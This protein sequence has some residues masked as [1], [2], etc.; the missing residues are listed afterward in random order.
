ML[1][2]Q[3]ATAYELLSRLEVLQDGDVTAA[4]ELLENMT[5]GT[6]VNASI[7]ARRI[8]LLLYQRKFDSARDLARGGVSRFTT[9]PAVVTMAMS[10]AGV[11]WSAGRLDA[12]R[13]L[14]RAAIRLIT[15]PGEDLDSI[16]HMALGLAHARLGDAAAAVKA[17]DTAQAI[18]ERSHD[19]GY[20]EAQRI[21]NLALIRLAL[22]DTAG[23]TE[24]LARCLA[25]DDCGLDASPAQLRVDPAWDPARADPRFQALLARH[26]ESD[27]KSVARHPS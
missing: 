24:E 26:P 19:T 12:A 10:R 6:P 13:E 8:E 22:G 17:N 5:P 25:R 21:Y 3:S 18:D 4:S 16:D 1:N 15:A 27:S 7:V 11:E 2:P 23:A 20:I 14:Y 9:G